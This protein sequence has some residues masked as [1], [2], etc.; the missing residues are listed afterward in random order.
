MVSWTKF[1]GL[2]S[3]QAD[4]TATLGR[5]AKH[6]L[7]K[8]LFGLVID[9]DLHGVSHADL[10]RDFMV[11]TG[12]AKFREHFLFLRNRGDRD[13]RLSLSWDHRVAVD[14]GVGVVFGFFLALAAVLLCLLL[15]DLQL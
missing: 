4:K 5:L 10:L 3:H 15:K 13:R 8:L 1:V 6:W 9:L 11:S 14:E 7:G 12:A 2:L